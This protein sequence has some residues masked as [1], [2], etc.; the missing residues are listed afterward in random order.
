MATNAEGFINSPMRSFLSSISQ[1]TELPCTQAVY[2]GR[3]HDTG[4]GPTFSCLAGLCWKLSTGLEGPIVWIRK[5]ALVLGEK[6]RPQKEHFVAQAAW[7]EINSSLGERRYFTW[8]LAENLSQI[9]KTDCVAT[10]FHLNQISHSYFDT[11]AHASSH[12][13]DPKRWAKGLVHI[14]WDSS[15]T[16]SRSLLLPT[17]SFL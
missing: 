3:P 7:A 9:P 14:E 6:C 8:H 2:L 13:Q 5:A 11:D 15:S 4:G 1:A 17:H 16:K 10:S 12:G